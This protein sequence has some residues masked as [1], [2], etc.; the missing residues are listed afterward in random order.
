MDTNKLEESVKKVYSH[1][2]KTISKRIVNAINKLE[3]D[4]DELSNDEIR[5]LT[6]AL[7][8]EETK[9]L[10]AEVEKLLAQKESIERAL[11]KKADEL[12]EAK[13]EIFNV[14]ED[15]KFS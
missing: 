12:Q 9:S 15:A 8:E 1:R 6:T 13:Y 2:F 4:L 11:E 10:Q 7:V 14:L 3:L 5:A